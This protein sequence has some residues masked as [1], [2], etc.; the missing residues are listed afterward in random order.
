[1]ALGCRELFDLIY[2]GDGKF[3]VTFEAKPH[4]E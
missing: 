2:Q 3:S 4:K 1:M